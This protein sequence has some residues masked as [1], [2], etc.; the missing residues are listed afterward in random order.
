M[1]VAEMKRMRT[2][3]DVGGK[4]TQ[5]RICRSGSVG[6]HLDRTLDSTGKGNRGDEGGGKAQTLSFDF[7]IMLILS[8]QHCKF[9]LALM[10]LKVDIFFLS[11][12]YSI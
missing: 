12:T 8:Q 2:R 11:L 1:P 7:Q 5:D 4:C 3:E 6:R 9:T 10:I